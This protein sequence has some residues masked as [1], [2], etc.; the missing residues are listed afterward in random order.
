MIKGFID[1]H[2]HLCYGVDDGAQ[3]LDDALAMIKAALEDGTQTILA[4]S[5]ITPGIR[6]F[7]TALYMQHLGDIRAA[8]E[9]EGLALRVLPGAEILYTEQ[10]ARFLHEEK[11]PTLGGTNYVL[12][13]FM[14]SVAYE[15][16]RKALTGILRSG[17]LPVV[18]HVE[19]YDCLARSPRRAAE[20][21]GELDVLF[22]MNCGTVI[23]G[24]GFFRDMR[25]KRLIDDG[26]IDI[27]ASD[28]HNVRSRC[29]K[30]QDAYKAL[31]ARCGAEDAKRMTGRTADTPFWAAIHRALELDA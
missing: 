15:D 21:H 25:A 6:P 28:A 20:L 31:K 3:T 5:H 24:K 10:T 30:M 18:A 9:D 14:P 13:E 22:Q 29:T 8:C 4:T 16:V 26:L 1:I 7:D 12:V 23:G 2:H 11:I 19:R 17:Y 27:V